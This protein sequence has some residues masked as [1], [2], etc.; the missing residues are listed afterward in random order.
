MRKFFILA[1]S[2][3]ILATAGCSPAAGST[4]TPSAAATSAA[5]QATSS[6]AATPTIT[7][8][9]AIAKYL[10]EDGGKTYINVEALRAD[11][12]TY[13]VVSSDNGFPNKSITADKA[14][15]ML[16][17]LA[18]VPMTSMSLNTQEAATSIWNVQAFTS[19]F[20]KLNG[21]SMTIKA[22][23]ETQLDIYIIAGGKTQRQVF[24]ISEADGKTLREIAKKKIE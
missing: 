13:Q 17:A 3:L 10:K 22:S 7:I 14:A 4:A 12:D 19:Q 20:G 1:L 24:S 18:K 9:Q 16:D 21:N 6:P 2:M 15:E 8:E 5:P 11:F 23:S